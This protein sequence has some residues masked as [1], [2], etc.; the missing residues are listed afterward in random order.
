MADQE[1]FS[2]ALTA[3]MFVLLLLVP[4]GSA[5]TLMLVFVSGVLPALVFYR[6]TLTRNDVLALVIATA[7]ATFLAAVLGQH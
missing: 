5:V 6:R 4:F 2:D 7:V 1:R 3:L